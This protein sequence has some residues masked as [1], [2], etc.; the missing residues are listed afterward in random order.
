M[1][2]WVLLCVFTGLMGGTALADNPKQE[3]LESLTTAQGM[4][5][6]GEINK[7]VEEI[8]YALSKLNEV[9][10]SDMLTFVPAPPA[11]FTL[12]S[13]NAQGMGQAASMVG[14]ASAEASYLGPDESNVKLTISTG[15]MTGKLGGLANLGS[16]FAGMA[17]DGGTKSVRIKGFTGTLQYDAQDRSGTLTLQVGEKT[18]VHAEGY[19]IA[20]ADVL[21]SLVQS[22]DLSKLATAF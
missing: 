21:K 3:A 5:K 14:N 12:E 8:N 6:Q 13:K 4:I 15:G 16:M 20:S 18:S 2:K 19:G 7:A 22:M 10:A 11:G 1:K 9:T 17:Q